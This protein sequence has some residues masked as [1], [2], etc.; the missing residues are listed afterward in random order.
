MLIFIL[1]NNKKTVISYS[2]D[3]NSEQQHYLGYRF[4]KGKRK[5]GIHLLLD[6]GN[7]QTM[8]YDPLNYENEDKVST[9]I[10]ANFQ[11]Q[12][13]NISDKLK[14]KIK[15]INTSELINKDFTFNNPSQ[16]FMI[17]NK[18]IVCSYSK[19]GDFID[20]VKSED[21]SFGELIDK[22]ILQVIT[23]LVYSKTDEV[24]YTTSKAI[25]TATNISLEKHALV[26]PKQR[27]L[28]DSVSISEDL[29][30]KKGDIIISIASGSMKHLGKVAYVEENIDKY[31]G[32]FL[33][34]IRSNDIEY[35]K[36][37]LYNLLSKRFRTFISRLKDQNINNLSTG[38]LRKFKIKIP[39]DIDEFNNLCIEKETNNNVI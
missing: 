17:D 24:P 4:S 21:I 34:I 39:K 13:L 33:S 10:R 15:Y 14:G 35:S 11:G 8:M 9:Y 28:K 29:K 1:N 27:Y 20:E 32:G 31:I 26:Y 2:G 18:D 3:K 6:D 23:G 19:Y 37:I 7:I 25:L 36:I 38:Q 12:S 30:P 22:D 16:F 5:E